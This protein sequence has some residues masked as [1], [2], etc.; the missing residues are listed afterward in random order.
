MEVKKSKTVSKAASDF[1]SIKVIEVEMDSEEIKRTKESAQKILGLMF[2]LLHKRG[3]PS[4][5]QDEVLSYGF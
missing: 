4:K 1:L 3:R 5:N 2:S